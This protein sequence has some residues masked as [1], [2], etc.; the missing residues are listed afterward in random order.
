ML[1]C[2][3]IRRFMYMRLVEF[4]K[5]GETKIENNEEIVFYTNH[6]GAF[7]KMLDKL[8][9]TFKNRP[10]ELIRMGSYRPEGQKNFKYISMKF[11]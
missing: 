3:S 7:E 8:N 10:H 1:V 4:A 9:K 6:G 2:F 11:Y 5:R